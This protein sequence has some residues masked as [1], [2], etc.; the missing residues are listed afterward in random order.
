M[1]ALGLDTAKVESYSD[2]VCARSDLQTLR[3]RIHVEA[4]DTLQETEAVVSLLR[5]DG[6]RRE[7]SHDLQSAVDL[8]SREQKVRSKAA[9]LIGR[10]KSGVAWAML[11]KDLPSSDF[12]KMLSS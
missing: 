3:A 10:A 9:S 7:S 2:E 1:Q 12:A 6:E 4:D 8:N 5:R 11:Q